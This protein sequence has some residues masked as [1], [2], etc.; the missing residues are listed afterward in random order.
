M[1]VA[2][3]FK[4]QSFYFPSEDEERITIIES[5]IRDMKFWGRQMQRPEWLCMMIAN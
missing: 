5:K 1:E 2:L 4:I 3:L